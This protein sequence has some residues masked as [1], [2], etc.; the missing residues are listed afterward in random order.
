MQLCPQ[1]CLLTDIFEL[2]LHSM[3]VKLATQMSKQPVYVHT[4]CCTEQNRENAGAVRQT[5]YL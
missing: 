2:C 1:L 4:D 3:C 5:V